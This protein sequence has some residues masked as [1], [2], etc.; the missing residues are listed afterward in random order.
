MIKLLDVCFLACYSAGS[1]KYSSYSVALRITGFLASTILFYVVS[2]IFLLFA[3]FRELRSLPP[4]ILVS[5]VLLAGIVTYII[6]YQI[7][8]RGRRYRPVIDRY[9]SMSK[10]MRII[11]AILFYFLALFSLIIVLFT[12]IL[13]AGAVHSDQG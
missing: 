9:K 12:G 5:S 1:K 8:I 11:L 3:I 4:L 2:M 7:Y 13:F 10:L 6:P